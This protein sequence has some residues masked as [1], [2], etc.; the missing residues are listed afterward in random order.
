MT[1]PPRSWLS[2]PWHVV[3]GPAVPVLALLSNNGPTMPPR[4]LVW[5]LLLGVAG[6]LSG[7]LLLTLAVRNSRTSALVTTIVT[8]TM[9]SHSTLARL[10]GAVHMPAALPFAYVL[11][12]L[13]CVRLLW[14]G[15]SALEVTTFAN[16]LLIALTLCFTSVVAWYEVSR[17][18]LGPERRAAATAHAAAAAE[19]PDIY[20]FI[21]D[22][23]GRA[24]VLKDLYGFDNELVPA[25]ESLGFYVAPRATSNYGQTAL[26]ISSALNGEYVQTLVEEVDAK[27]RDRRLLGDLI[28]HSRVF[29]SLKAAGYR[30][31]S[32]ASEY[33]LIRPGEIDARP[34]PPLPV[35]E[36]DFALYE[37]SAV[38]WAAQWLGG[39]GWL[40]M[41]LHRQ[42]LLWTLDQL[43]KEPVD[44]AKEPRLTFAHLLLPHPPFVFNADGGVRPTGLP[45]TLRDGPEWRLAARGT[46]E[47]YERG[48]ADAVHFL[49]GR[50][51]EIVEG[52]IRR[53]RRPFVIYMQGDHGPGAGL[54]SEY[55]AQT[56]VRERF[57]I[58]LAVRLP[59][60]DRGA[61][62]PDITP[63]NAFRLLLNRAIGTA[64]P[65]LANRSYFSTWPRPFDLVDVTEQL[66]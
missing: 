32:Y 54:T 45:V 23:Y 12:L 28:G 11:V 43:A 62:A 63:V 25:L 56:N 14:S 52:I 3:L 58:L 36:F 49:N 37:E 24:D 22:G 10:T 1:A 65:N 2:R 26:S 29:A 38:P 15:G 39:G 40:P 19:R 59:G 21:L 5:P 27:G 44:P 66:R 31:R 61:V 30:I 18:S 41:R 46:H 48:Y 17:P 47:S 33:P 7:W 60:G 64:L 4:V 53:S 34:R 35:T 50:I 42:H 6:A 16:F 20:V 9:L 13:I 57:G 51:V 8:L 55:S